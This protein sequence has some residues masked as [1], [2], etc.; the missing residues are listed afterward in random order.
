MFEIDL[1]KEF[2]NFVPDEQALQ[3]ILPET[4]PIDVGELAPIKDTELEDTNY[5]AFVRNI[6]KRLRSDFDVVIAIDGETGEG[7]STLAI[8]LA[9][10]IDPHFTIEN[11]I[12]ML[13]DKQNLL[14]I[15]NKNVCQYGVMII[16]EADRALN[17]HQWQSREQQFINLWYAT[18]RYQN[19]CT[20][21]CLPRFRNLTENFRNFRVNIW[22]RVM[23][24][25]YAIVYIKDRDKDCIDPWYQKENIKI[26][27][28]LFV[29][30]ISERMTYDYVMAERKLPNYLFEFRFYDLEE[31]DKVKYNT[32][33]VASR[34][35]LKQSQEIG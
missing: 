12:A 16:D 35:Q 10:A 2:E 7:K 31:E 3:D 29:P 26:K 13:P 9:R 6:R 5:R 17:K 27:S 8:K 18:E 19:K 28:K 23:A 21:I 11:N 25:G 34:E 24:R 15:F 4:T 14:D 32:L 20:I 30:F 22:I 33:K 1:R